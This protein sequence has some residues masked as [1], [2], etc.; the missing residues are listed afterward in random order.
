MSYQ[1]T[2]QPSGR[3]IDAAAG[4]RV[5]DAALRQGVELPY[6]CRNGECATCIAQLCS[7]E[8]DYEEYYPAL[9]ALEEGE[10][11]LCQARVRSDLVIEAE[12]DAPVEPPRCART[13]P[14]KVIRRQRLDHDVMGL[15][16]KL[17]EAQPLQFR[18]GQ[19]LDVLTEGGRRSFSI[20]SAPHQPGVL[21]LHIRRI[22]GGEFTDYVFDQ[23]QDKAIWRI[24]APLGTF[25]LHEDSQ[26]PILM[27]GGGTGFAPLKGMV[28]HAI[29]V[30]LQ[31]PIHLFWGVRARRDLYLAELPEHWAREHPN[32][33]YTPV[34][35][36]P[37]A[38]D[39]WQG[40]RGFVHEALLR[41][42]PEL[43]DYDIYMSG[44]PAMIEAAGEAFLPRGARTERM[45]ADAYE[46]NRLISA[47]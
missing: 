46:F 5:L 9:D 26:R 44:P 37:D 24:E 25:Y 16:L 40:E 30:G 28:E 4:E 20:A 38:D 45:F 7:G 47:A 27:M 23:L 19:Y 1:I 12:M 29:H 15:W 36:E 33:R 42:Y 32:V 14:C 21:E 10:A 41:R 2:I 22:D 6:S 11:I 43:R 17:P 8:V 34:L 35:S 3:I 13:L 18:A 39:H 31:R